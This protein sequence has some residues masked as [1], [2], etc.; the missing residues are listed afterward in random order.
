[1][2]ELAN[3]F[4][5]SLDRLTNVEQMAAKTVV[6]DYMADPSRPGLSL[7]RID[8]ARDKG[9]WTIRVNRDLRIV[10]FK[11]NQ[12]SV[13]CYV[14]HHDDAYAWAERRRFEVH[15]VTG[16][17]QI[18]ELIE[19]IREEVRTVT[20]E[21]TKPRVLANEDKDY[22]LSLGVPATYLDLV[23]QVDEDGLLE[24]LPRLPEEAQEALMAVA[25]GERP[26]PR[27]VVRASLQAD[28]FAHPDAQRRFWVASDEQM[29]TQAL[30]KP[31]AEWLVFL[32]PSQ[33]AAVEKNFTG[34]ARISGSAGTGKSVVAMHRAA[35]LA[36]E[37]QSGRILLT[38][39]S[40]VLAGRLVVGMDTLLGHASD[41]RQKVEVA[42]LHAYAH[43][44]AS[45]LKQLVIADDRTID[46]MIAE[47]RVGLPS[48]VTNEFLR[49]EWDSIIDYW[50]IKSFDEYKAIP[51]TGRGTPVAAGVRRQLWGVFDQVQRKLVTKGLYTFGD[52]CDRLRQR[53]EEDGV[54]PFQ[55]V[56][57]DEAQDLGP[58]ELRLIAA[59]APGGPRALI[60]AGDVGQRIFRWPFS[61]LN[62]GIDV[63]GRSQRLRV[64][65]RTTAEIRRFSDRLLP[66]SLTEVDGE[67][68]ERGAVSLLRGP[69]PEI[70]GSSELSGEIETLIKWLHGL[71]ERGVAPDEMIA[72]RRPHLV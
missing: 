59:L 62:A 49:S 8:R 15:P 71:R 26:E 37:P 50:G 55:H 4:H 52:I 56:V 36:R 11:Q 69:S 54:R 13:F 57:V 22:L 41:A 31:W 67:A 3:T 6:F 17:A 28:P 43:S 2:L 35:Y 48:T 7:H 72:V 30:E 18:V 16:A 27:P 21:A 29:V 39:F 68:E 64:N 60:F 24:L 23:Q 53:I 63:R 20:R 14:G 5:R 70:K 33:R 40:K 46:E 65:Y 32:H 34:P 1:M 19:I 42:H 38:T 10:V 47:A 45:R 25:T 51:R 44:H 9:F 61:W 58:R 12:K 66:A